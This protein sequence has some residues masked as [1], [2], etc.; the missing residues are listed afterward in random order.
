M[1]KSSLSENAKKRINILKSSD[2]GFVIS[3]EDMKLRG[4]GDLLG[5]KQSGIKNFRFADPVHHEDLFQLAEKYIL[6]IRDNI[7]EKKYSFLLKLFDKAEI[8][9]VEEF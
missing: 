1:F 8:I 7:N 6:G 3:E 5:F 4:Y 9:N 2:D